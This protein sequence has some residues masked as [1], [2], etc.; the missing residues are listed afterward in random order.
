MTLRRVIMQKCSYRHSSQLYQQILPKVLKYFYHN[1]NESFARCICYYTIG[2]YYTS[3]IVRK[4]V[5]VKLKSVYEFVSGEFLY[6]IIFKIIKYMFH[7]QLQISFH[8]L[9]IFPDYL[10]MNRDLRY[11]PSLHWIA[12]QPT[13]LDFW[14]C[15]KPVIEVV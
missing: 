4:R 1:K 2:L 6:W 7:A 3:A 14:Q 11:T 12:H 13:V 8:S 15:D 5:I 9:L 10:T